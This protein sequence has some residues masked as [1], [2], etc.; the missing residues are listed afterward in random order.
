MQESQA[1]AYSTN[2][3]MHSDWDGRILLLGVGGII[4]GTGLFF[5]GFT[6]LKRRQMIQNTPTSKIRS[7]AMG[8]VEVHG[9]ALPAEKNIM[10]SPFSGRKCVW[11]RYTIEEYRTSGKHHYW[12]LVKNGDSGVPFFVKDETGS[13]L[14]NPKGAEV[15]VPMDYHCDSGF[16]K[17]PPA[18]VKKFLKSSALGFEGLFGINSTMRYREYF[19]APGDKVYIMGTA[20]DNPHIEEGRGMKN[21]EDIMI[22]KGENFFYISDKH[23]KDVVSSMAW[24][25]AASTAGGAIMAV[26]GLAITLLY[27][28]LL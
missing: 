14:V 11:Y 9:K 22:Q 25:V 18:R 15:D 13:V 16:G 8:P 12:A 5:H 4:I 21:E 6:L 24:K 2:I 19:I 7:M 23:E 27:L 1:F 17:D 20:A 26:G 10:E 3:V 28:G